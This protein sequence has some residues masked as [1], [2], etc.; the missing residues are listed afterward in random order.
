[1]ESK[2]IETPKLLLP[3]GFYLFIQALLLALFIYSYNET[4]ILEKRLNEIN[5]ELLQQQVM[6][7]R[8]QKEFH[9]QSYLQQAKIERM[10]KELK[11]EK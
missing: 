6:F 3:D 5:E 7:D 9:E 1:M 2:T 11:S 4:L 10:V 8:R